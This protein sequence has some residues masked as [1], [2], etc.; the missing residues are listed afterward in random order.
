MLRF[1]GEETK[2][3]NVNVQGNVG[4]RFVKTTIESHGNVGY[5]DRA[6]VQRRARLGSGHLQCRRQRHQS[7]D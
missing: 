6:V 3:G 4:V 7:G 2:L 1:G 5:P